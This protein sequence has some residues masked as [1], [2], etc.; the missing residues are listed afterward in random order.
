MGMSDYVRRLRA[1]I[2]NDLLLM[3]AVGGLLRDE[4]GRILL[5]QH[6]EG[7]W[8]LPGGAVDPG[9]PPAEAL[10]RECLEEAGVVVEP[11]AI[12]GAFGGPEYQIRYSN[13]DEAGYVVTVFE[14]RYVDGEPAPSDDETQAVGWFAP[15]ELD[16][17]EIAPSTRATLRAVLRG[18]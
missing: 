13:G 15:E 18:S 8:Q 5:V 6:V 3:P 12:L 1:K 4:R 2:G 16:G 7:R 10:R 11:T 9:E 17:L 14:L